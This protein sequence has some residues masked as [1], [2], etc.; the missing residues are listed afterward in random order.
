MRQREKKTS[1]LGARVSDL[2]ST[3]MSSFAIFQRVGGREN[4]YSI[5]ESPSDSTDL[6]MEMKFK[7]SFCNSQEPGVIHSETRIFFKENETLQKNN[8]TYFLQKTRTSGESANS[9]KR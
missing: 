8:C 3:V 2:P 9:I 1:R 7:P 4:I 5:P 6:E